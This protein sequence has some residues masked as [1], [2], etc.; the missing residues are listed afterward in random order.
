MP[1]ERNVRNWVYGW[2]RQILE[3]KGTERFMGQKENFVGDA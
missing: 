3:G 2:V 1:D